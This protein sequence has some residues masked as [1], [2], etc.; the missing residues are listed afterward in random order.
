MSRSQLVIRG[1][2]YLMIETV[3]EC[4]QV[5]SAWVQAVYHRGLLGAGERRGESI[6]IQ[7]RMLDRVA[8][9]QRLNILLDEDMNAVA[10]FIDNLY[11]KMFHGVWRNMS[12]VGKII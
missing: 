5:Q 4:F 2:A 7:A 12:F 6:Y 11:L 9:I 1:E 8:E 10:L 3:A